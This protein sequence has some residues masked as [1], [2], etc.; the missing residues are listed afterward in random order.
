M[1]WGIALSWQKAART[2]IGKHDLRAGK[3]LGRTKKAE[4]IRAVCRNPM[5]TVAGRLDKRP[6]A[7]KNAPCE[8][9][10]NHG[11]RHIVKIDINNEFGRYVRRQGE[12]VGHAKRVL[13]SKG[14]QLI[15]LVADASA[16]PLAKGGDFGPQHACAERERDDR[17]AE[18]VVFKSSCL[19]RSG[20][21]PP[22]QN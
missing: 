21:V 7:A 2:R 13:L 1:L 9:R 15:F 18:T 8:L 5:A 10:I 12:F 20:L 19:R 3:Y 6:L 22:Q 4:N 11:A 14:C 17:K 16:G